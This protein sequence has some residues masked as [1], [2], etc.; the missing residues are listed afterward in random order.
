MIDFFIKSVCNSSG[1]FTQQLCAVRDQLASETAKHK[2]F[3]DAM[4]H[5]LKAE[6]SH[7]VNAEEH[8]AKAQHEVNHFKAEHFT[9]GF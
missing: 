9:V 2:E 7:R 4:T 8:L 1:V 3:H 5:K 6:E